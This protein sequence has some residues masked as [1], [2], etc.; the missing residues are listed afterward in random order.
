[1]SKSL[2]L[3]VALVFASAFGGL[4]VP[5]ASAFLPGRTENDGR[6]PLPGEGQPVET[7]PPA[8]GQAKGAG[9]ASFLQRH[10]GWDGTFYRYTGTPHRAFGAGIAVTGPVTSAAQAAE[11][12]ER[13]LRQ[14]AAVTKAGPTVDLELSK[15]I[16]AQRVW[17]VHF[18]QRFEGV[19]LLGTDVTVRLGEDGKVFAF[20]SDVRSDIA[21]DTRPRLSAEEARQRAVEGLAFDPD[22]DHARGGGSLFVLPLEADGTV[23]YVLVRQVE[24]SQAEPR[25]EWVAMVDAHTGEVAWRFDRVRRGSVNG[26]QTS[27][28]HP[29]VPSDPLTEVPNRN[30]FVNVGGVDVLTSDLGHYLSESVSDSVD[31]LFE[32]RGP[33]GHA[34]RAD[35]KPDAR[36]VIRVD[37]DTD[38]SVDH[39]WDNTNSQSNE[40]D[41]FF[42][43]ERTHEYI[44]SIDPGFTAID[45]EM[46]IHV[47]V[48]G[49][50]NAYWDGEGV[51]FFKAGGGCNSTAKMADVVA[52]EYGHGI[53]DR[54]YQQA[55]GAFM[56]NG[57]LHEGMADVTAAFLF[58]D[59]VI[60]DE[61][62]TSGATSTLRN[63]DNTNHLPEDLVGESHTDGQIIAG[64]FWDLREAIGLE[65][66]ER[67]A[68]FAK[69]GLPDH[70]TNAR[71][72]FREY[73][74]ET[75]VADD[76]DSDLSNGTPHFDEIVASFALHGIDRT[77]Y[78][79]LRHDNVP[80]VAGSDPVTIEAL[81]SSTDEQAFPIDPAS[82]ELFYSVDRE[83]WTRLPMA[84]ISTR[85]Y[86]AD[87]PGQPAGSVVS[88]YFQ[89]AVAG[90]EVR[91][92]PSNPEARAYQYIVGAGEQVFFD[93]FRSD[94]GW[95]VGAP[96]DDAV[97]G[98]WERAVPESTPN[99]SQ[100]GGDH[101][102]TDNVCYVTGAQAG[103]GPGDF[104][105]DG[106]KTTL[107][108]PVFDLSSDGPKVIDYWRIFDNNLGYVPGTPL[109]DD[110]WV[111]E[112]SNDG[113][114]SW[115]PVENTL[116]SDIGSGRPSN[117]TYDDWRRFAFSVDRFVTPTDRVQLRFIARDVGD[118]SLVEALLDDFEILD[119]S[120]GVPTLLSRW[121]LEESE[122]AVWVRW[123]VP[124]GIEAPTFRLTASASGSTW[125]VEFHETS[126]GD[127]EGMDRRALEGAAPVTYRL[128]AREGGGDWTLLR[129]ESLKPRGPALR[130]ELLEPWPNPCNPSTTVA[131]SVT[132]G[133]RVRLAVY[134]VA[135]REIA[136]L[137][138]RRFERGVHR[139]TWTGVDSAGRPVASG[140]YFLRMDS[141]A[142]RDGRKLVLI[143]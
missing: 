140:V 46:P 118:P 27:L 30:M 112:I 64:A 71:T 92:V 125:P 25:H 135:G 53:N 139:L 34:R 107:T 84:K 104:D 126:S 1:M 3:L 133:G 56:T 22:R 50:C 41:A 81:L 103:T 59:P 68:H 82:V 105:V 57:A 7:A 54:L 122:G 44:K 108:S 45:Y 52:H 33:Y 35:G 109:P 48:D 120:P 38:P 63:L 10:P 86:T 66:A 21:L 40:R 115:V 31:V 131:F 17:Y 16:Q 102:P 96:D 13:F 32:I 76:D 123:A 111:V 101:T 80:D 79:D 24:V 83:T 141:R 137:A 39:L 119:F 42:T 9:W 23:R 98:T 142:T 15:A 113:G 74:V 132:S 11:A 14:E 29:R 73:L 90:G 12:A 85:T 77:L 134:D 110:P 78:V 6:V 70:P 67:L 18:R 62:F 26:V 49:T 87:V 19:P 69:Y 58:D 138:D 127:Y 5:Q 136:R 97:T 72:A 100:P 121:R 106:G 60:G 88:Y 130:D 93:S 28:V 95:T 117:G 99:D 51:N 20:G 43:A 47:L 8:A 128:Y 37:A 75:L 36:D 129:E 61:F 2:R 114:A 116:V 91:T 4:L 55:G 65:A 124:A 143:R 94:K 89:A